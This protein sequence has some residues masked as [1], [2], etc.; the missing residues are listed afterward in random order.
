MFLIASFLVSRSH[1]T[2]VEEKSLVLGGGI[3]VRI[4]FCLNRT[5]TRCTVVTMVLSFIEGADS[6]IAPPRKPAIF[7]NEHYAAAQYEE[8]CQDFHIRFLYKIFM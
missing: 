6:T 7:F 3:V 2:F 8:I 1:E 5:P 4:N